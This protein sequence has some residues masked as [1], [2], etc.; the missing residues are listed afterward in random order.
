VTKTVV[1]ALLAVAGA[2]V[3]VIV[4]AACSSNPSRSECTAIVDRLVDI[5]TVGKLSDEGGG[6]K[7][8]KAYVDAVETWR[9]MLK[10]D[11]DATHELLMHMCTTQI[12]SGAQGCILAAKNERD[13]AVCL[14]Q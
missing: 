14:G 4:G 1:L 6:A 5:F 2:L 11:K 8:P 13:L 3:T 7:P 12:S 9:R 10:D